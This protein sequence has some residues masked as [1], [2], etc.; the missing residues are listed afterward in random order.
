MGLQC[1]DWSEP[2]LTPAQWWVRK[3]STRVRLSRGDAWLGD[4]DV[5]LALNVKR[6]EGHK[7]KT[8]ALNGKLKFYT[9]VQRGNLKVSRPI[10][11]QHR[12]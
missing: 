4:E 6:S 9:Y 3:C 10:K 8:T 7:V 11:V 2:Y 5:A 12:V 1:F